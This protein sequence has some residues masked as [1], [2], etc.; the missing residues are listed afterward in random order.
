M[1]KTLTIGTAQ[2]TVT[3]S[4]VLLRY[5]NIGSFLLGEQSFATEAQAI[6][7]CRIRS[8]RVL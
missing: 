1:T 7:F 3:G 8:L 5:M 4:G 2:I 6:E